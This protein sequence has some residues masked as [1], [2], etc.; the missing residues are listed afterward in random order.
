MKDLV[1]LGNDGSIA[2]AVPLFRHFEDN[3]LAMMDGYTISLTNGKPVAFAM[4]FGSG[5]L[6][7]VN[8]ELV[9]KAINEQ[10]VQ[11]LGEL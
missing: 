8:A 4:D 7:L 2:I 6:E 9:E 3:A 11:C 5:N 10:R 1:I